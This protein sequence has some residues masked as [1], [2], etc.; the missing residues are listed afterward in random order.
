MGVRS[1]GKDVRL[2]CLVMRCIERTI[3]HRRGPSRSLFRRLSVAAKSERRAKG[4]GYG[5]VVDF[6]GVSELPP[7]RQLLYL[8]LHFQLFDLRLVFADQIV[9]CQMS[10]GQ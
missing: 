3:N 8:F 2:P 7:S 10:M 4:V 5:L 9:W 6:H 1:E